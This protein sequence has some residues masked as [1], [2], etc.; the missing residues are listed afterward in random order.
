MYFHVMTS[1]HTILYAE[2]DLDDLYM[3]RKAFES[4]DHIQVLHASNGEEALQH[5]FTLWENE[6]KPCLIILDIN[7]PILNGR[8]ALVKIKNMEDFKEIPVVLFSTSS[9]TVDRQFAESY[10]VE[11]VTKPLHYHD[12]E[13]IAVQFVNKCNF[14]INKLRST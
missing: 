12:L 9:S 13:N 3:V 14:E 5:L 10:Q 7:M 6:V 2:D 8:E 4:H 1:R 11:L